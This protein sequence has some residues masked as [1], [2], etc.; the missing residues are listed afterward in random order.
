MAT[1]TITEVELET[2]SVTGPKT[3]QVD[4]APGRP[5]SEA[6]PTASNTPSSASIV[7]GAYPHLAKSRAWI[8]ITQLCGINFVSSFSNGLVSIG[9]PTMA[10]A[11]NI[12]NNLLLW[13]SSAFHL[14]MGSC[15]LIAGSVADVIGPRRVNLPGALLTAVMILASGFAKDAITLIMLQAIQGIANA[16]V[17]PTAISIVSNNVEEG[18][19]RNIGFASIFLSMPLGFAVGMIVGGLFVSTVGWEVGFYIG[20]GTGLLLVVVAMWA[21]PKDAKLGPLTT[22]LKR[23]AVE[24]DWVGAAIASAAIALLSY[25]LAML[26]AETA[27]IKEASNIALLVVSLLLLPAFAMWMEFQVKRG[28][29]ALIPNQLWKNIPFT[30]VC[31]MI[32]LCNA[33]VNCMELYSSLFFQEVQLLSAIQTAIRILPQVL[34]GAILSLLA[35]VLVNRVPVMASIMIS[36]V[37][38]A[39]SPLLMAVIDPSRSYWIMAFWAQLLAPFGVDVLFTVGTLVVS[40]AFPRKTQALAGAV[41]NT[42]AQVGTSIGLCITSVISLSVTEQSSVPNQESPQALMQ[43]YR[44]AFWALFAWMIAACVIGLFGLRTVG[45]VGIKRE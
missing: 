44:A 45:K 38:A 43:G 13:P 41:F 1:H 5:F 9:L 35:G 36:S 3:T 28:R 33:V 15:L 11:I 34:V 37:L 8:V 23:L 21:L 14:T 29:P 16:M 18:T 22:T 42:F 25:I 19:A 39:G 30:S 40:E 12:S 26:S 10:T 2:Y 7:E 6:T 17:V 27:H 4:P 24:I 20:G 31:L 32:L